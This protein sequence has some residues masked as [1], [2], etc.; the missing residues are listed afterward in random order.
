V[1]T[2]D[3]RKDYGE[4]RYRAF[5]TIDDRLHVL[6][7]AARGAQ[8]RVISL[9]RANERERLGYAETQEK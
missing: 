3:D 6:I 1:I 8:T 2:I 9:R 7:F 4:V 5:G